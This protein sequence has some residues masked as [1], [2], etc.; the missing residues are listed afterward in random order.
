MPISPLPPAQIS[1]PVLS[2][3]AEV[4]PITEPTTTRHISRTPEFVL[5]LIGGIFGLLFIPLMVFLGG[6]QEAFTGETTLY[7]QSFVAAL[8]SVLGLVGAVFVRSRPKASG[9][10][11][12][13]SGIVGIIVA[14]GFYVGAL[15]LLIAGILALVRKPK[16]T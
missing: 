2:P 4:S 9:I 7:A 8:M 3:R 6:F 5:G 11:L 13:V 16:T 15:L 14:L 12:L 1:G 10:L